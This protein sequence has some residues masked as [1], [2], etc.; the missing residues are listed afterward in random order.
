VYGG[1]TYNSTIILTYDKQENKI[2]DRI[3]VPFFFAITDM[4]Q[5]WIIGAWHNC[6]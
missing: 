5:G 2:K 6:D 3:E 1:E 4:Q